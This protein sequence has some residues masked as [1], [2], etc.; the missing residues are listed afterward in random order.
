[1]KYGITMVIRC[2]R[3]VGVVFRIGKRSRLI[4]MRSMGLL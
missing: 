4:D 3:I 2:E 1:M